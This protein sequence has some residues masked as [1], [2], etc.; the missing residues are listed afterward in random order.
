MAGETF[1]NRVQ[2][3]PKDLAEYIRSP[4]GPVFRSMSIAGDV[5]K[6]RAQARVGVWRPVPG[7]PFAARRA[8]RR[9][10]GTLRDSIVK[11]I[12][13]RGGLPVVLVGSDDPIAL[14]HH[15]GTAPHT[16][17]ARRR[18]R[19]VFF[20]NGHVQRRLQ[21]RHPGTSPNRYLTDSLYVI[22]EL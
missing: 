22:P 1:R 3:D 20:A 2:I 4:Q 10:P 5:V 7:D 19:L 13:V 12:S 11:R 9:R 16:I 15:E 21:V 17:R 6:R 14:I 8:A 18:P